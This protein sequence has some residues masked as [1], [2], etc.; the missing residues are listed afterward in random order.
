MQTSS[1]LCDILSPVIGETL[2]SGAKEFLQWDTAGFEPASRSGQGS[3]SKNLVNIYRLEGAGDFTVDVEITTIH[4][5][6][7]ETHL[8]TLLLETYW[9]KHDLEEL[10][11]LLASKG[12]RK[13]FQKKQSCERAKRV[14]VAMTRPRE[15]LCLAVHKEHLR[16]DQIQDLN[17]AGWIVRDLTNRN[18]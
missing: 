3:A 11:P 7:G 5:V 15:L 6:K 12:D 16:E 4:A 9:H 14:F 10:L 17:D 8:A 2:T 1:E 18:V 13:L